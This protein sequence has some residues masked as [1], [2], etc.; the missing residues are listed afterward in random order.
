MNLAH[1]QQTFAE[2]VQWPESAQSVAHIVDD[3]KG[4]AAER[5]FIYQH[6]YYAR[7]R[8]ALQTD[9]PGLFA[10]LGTVEF[11]CLARVYSQAYPS[12]NPSLRWFGQHLADLLRQTAP[13]RNQSVL[14]ELACFEWA[15]GLSFDA[16]NSPALTLADLQR[17]PPERWGDLCIEFAPSMQFLDLHWNA[18]QIW[19]ALDREEVPPVPEITEH[20]IRWLVWR[21]GLNPHWRSLPVDESWALAELQAGATLSKVCTGLME[22]IDEAQIPQRLMELLTG[23]LNDEL[24]VGLQA[25]PPA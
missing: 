8:E 25:Q 2:D 6:A 15:L 23:W 19:Q 12:Q 24:L 20:P 10:Y 9:Y 22:W 17:I 16:A 1:L 7:L 3:T 18:P 13:Y 11:E 14:S 21:R 4:R 5:L